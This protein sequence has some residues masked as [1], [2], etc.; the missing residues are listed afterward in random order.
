MSKASSASRPRYRRD[1]R[2]LWLGRK[3][4]KRFRQRAPD[5]HLILSAFEEQN[6]QRRIDCPLPPRPLEDRKRRLNRAIYRLNRHQTNQL[7]RFRGDGTGDGVIW[8]RWTRD[9]RKP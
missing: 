6:W 9:R 5:Q 8:E 2:E 7:I 3:L 1:L 4:V